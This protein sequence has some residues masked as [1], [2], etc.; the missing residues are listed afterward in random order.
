[1]EYTEIRSPRLLMRPLTM[2]ELESTYA[3]SGD[4]E[5]THFMMYLPYD[6]L[7][8][9]AG[10]I[11]D[12]ENEWRKDAPDRC[13]FAIWYEGAHIGGLTVYFLPDRSEI[14]LGW[15]L[16]R[17]YWRRGLVTEA[18]RAMMAYAKEHWNVRRVIACCDSANAASFGLMEKLGMRL[19]SSIPGRRNR[20]MPDERVE[21]TC[22]ILL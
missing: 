9:T 4:L 22:E 10:A 17:D 20:S 1:M 16:H 5:N 14:E 13:E 8:E 7:E 2:A 15:V 12:A 18:A 21:L 3:Y 19:V 11:R 6:S